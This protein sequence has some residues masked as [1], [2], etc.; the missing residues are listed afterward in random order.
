METLIYYLSEQKETQIYS[1]N[2]IPV[3]VGSADDDTLG[4]GAAG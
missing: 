1:V 2:D 3:I 4:F